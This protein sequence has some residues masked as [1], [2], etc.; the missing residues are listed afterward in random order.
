MS[1]SSYDFFQLRFFIAVAEELNFRRAAARLNMTQ[2]PLSR[3]IKMLED[4]IG[5]TLFERTNKSVR[6]TP[7]GENFLKSATDLM[8]RAEYAVLSARQA[9][10]GEIGSIAMGF[11]PSASLLF[12]PK[13]VSALK[14]ELPNVRFDP[15]EMMT[16]EIAEGLQSGKLDFGLMRTTARVQ[17]MQDILLVRE[18]F[19][20]ALPLG[21]PLCA[22]P[23]LDITDLNGQD[24]IGYSSERGGFLKDIHRALFTTVGV[25][26]KT[27]QEVSQTQTIV[28][29]VNSG[30][31]VGLVPESS[32]VM[33][34]K[35]VCFRPID[36][37]R[38]FNSMLYLNVAPNRETR[39]NTRVKEIIIAALQTGSDD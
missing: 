19:V 10:R 2:P 25:T 21:H 31:G 16:Y 9:E 11:V 14:R 26:P 12:V 22:V 5:L 15:I 38:E 17:E 30:L 4:R 29:L 28:A 8:Q 37:P 35:N 32:A 39:L 13:I 3:Q 1:Q 20:L 18:P 24:F 34:M 27:V 7:A 33:E 36:A 23:Q 6:L